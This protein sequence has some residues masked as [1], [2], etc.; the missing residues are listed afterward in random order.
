MAGAIPPVG[1]LN[2]RTSCNDTSKNSRSTELPAATAKPIS[3]RKA[4][5]SL[6]GG[7]ALGNGGNGV[8]FTLKNWSDKP[9]VS[10][11]NCPGYPPNR[12]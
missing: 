7:G 10:S 3:Q 1:T 2:G 8:A 5:C 4:R 6:S 11:L 9:V 12:F